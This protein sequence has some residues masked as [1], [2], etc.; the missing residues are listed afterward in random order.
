MVVAGPVALHVHAGSACNAPHRK[1]RAAA[2]RRGATM[3]DFKE[4]QGETV[5]DGFIF[6]NK[7][8]FVMGMQRSGTTALL[9]ALG[10]D[11]SLQVEN[12]QPDGPIWE[13]YLLR[14][15]PEIRDL[16]W[17]F[18]RRLILK[19]VLEIERRSIDALLEEFREYDPLVVWIYRDPVNV[20][21]SAK[22]EFDLR[23]E[24]RKQWIAKWV[25]GN[26]SA[27]RSLAGPHGGRIAAV[28]YED[29]IE[30]RDVFD[31]LC[32]FLAIEPRNNLFWR[33]DLKKG[34][35]SL[36]SDVQRWIEEQTAATL[37]RMNSR[38]L[39]AEPRRGPLAALGPGGAAEGG[40]SLLL[41]ENCRARMAQPRPPAV[42]RVEID[43]SDGRFPHGVQLA[44][45]PLDLRRGRKYD[46]CVWARAERRRKVTVQITQ[47]YDPWELVGPCHE[48]ELDERWRPIAG[49]FVADRDEANARL[50]FDLGQDSAAVET[51]GLIFGA[52][53]FCLNRLDVHDASSASVL[54]LPG[55]RNGARIEI[56]SLAER[57]PES[58]QFVAGSFDIDES[59]SYSVAFRAR[60][61]RPRSVAVVVG[62]DRAP[63][64]TAGLYQKASL[65]P[66]WQTCFYTFQ[67]TKAGPA[68][69]YFDLGEEEGPV[70]ISDVAVAAA[71][72]HLNDLFE[73]NGA[74][75]SV[76]FPPNAPGVIRLAVEPGERAAPDDVQMFVAHRSIEG[77]KRYFASFQ[78]RADAPRN[79]G[80]GVV[81]GRTAWKGVGL[82]YTVGVGMQWK[83][84]YYEFVAESDAADV[85]VLF[86]LGDSA[87]P[88]EIKDVRFEEAVQDLT[89]DDVRRLSWIVE[90]LASSK[91]IRR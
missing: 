71:E 7:L 8:I 51:T 59:A 44:W 64:E 81:R 11:P 56:E 9:Y 40:W 10:Q 63:W 55:G 19:P 58:V 49:S 1:I 15:E 4:S 18:K 45:A 32:R 22:A 20:W 5:H 72:S 73:R 86:D 48:L 79:V 41:N 80:F 75:C 66:D 30:R 27:L 36:P 46:C 78:G 83:P 6:R 33:E 53:L 47:N 60:A 52:P 43:Q 82:Y 62:E 24:E 65:G 84:Y 77:G 74:R 16:L 87:A 42:A 31:E 35:R 14:P 13:R 91:R 50:L 2:G 37:D 89:T 61:D 17:S 90:G 39:T 23:Q 25:E 88:I 38:R 85:R 3:D 70:E 34:R 57:K 21:S 28:R 29:L 12:E 67:S 76:E 68:R 54:P 26:E 69:V